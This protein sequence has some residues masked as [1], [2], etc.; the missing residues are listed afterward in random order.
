VSAGSGVR[1]V[2]AVAGC[3][4][5]LAGC[6]SSGSTD[7]RAALKGVLL[8][9]SDFPPSW[10]SFPAS[11]PDIDVLTDLAKCTG[12]QHRGERRELVR[13]GTFRNGAQRIASTAVSFDTQQDVSDRVAAIG[14]QKT[15]DCLGGILDAAVRDAV[16]GATPVHSTYHAIAGAINAAVNLVGTADGVVTVNGDG[17]SRK[18]YVDVSF[19]TGHNF[20]AYVT[21]IGV[22]KRISSR[23]RTIVTTDVASRGQHV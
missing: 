5:A 20:Y 18:V 7:T 23:I 2:L 17:G 8:Q 1:R 12:D 4:L 21:F 11:G 19:V 9:L 14:N 13:S 6:T 22:G 15:P 10:R 16:P 3:C